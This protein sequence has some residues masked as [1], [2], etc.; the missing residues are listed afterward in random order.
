MALVMVQGH[1]SDALLRADIRTTPLYQLEIL[2]HGSTAPG[3]LFASGFVAGLPRAPLS[4]R[5]SLRRARRLLFV[6]G[7]GYALH[8][9]YF[10]LWK[11]LDA[12]P[13]QKAALFACDALQVIA[14]TQLGVLLLQAAFGRRWTVA[15]GALG[16]LIVALSPMLWAA[17]VSER[18]PPF[19]AAY[20]DNRTGSIFPVFPFAAFVLAGNV[21]GALL[22]RQ[23]PRVRHRRALLFGAFAL[24]AG[25][26]LAR[27]LEGRVDFWSV[28]PAYVLLRLGGLVLLLRLVEVA[29]A[30]GLP[31]IPMLALLGRETLLVFVLHLYLLFGGIVGAP[32]LGPWHGA[33]GLSAVAVVLAGMVLALFV[34][35]WLWRTAKHHAPQETSFALSFLTAAFLFEFV[36]RPW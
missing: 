28:S 7:V 3:F 18:L 16:V 2:F 10:S 9:P 14:V 8:L 33:L 34:A 31:G 29:A 17:Q 15:A 25:F 11:T 23:D 6:L 19:L 4:L 36:T 12:S 30:R 1:V 24:V 21:A 32:P 26:V 5:A 27:L 13:A 22:G 20:V 35:A